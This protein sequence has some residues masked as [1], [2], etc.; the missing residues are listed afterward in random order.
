[1]AAPI[2]S[3]CSNVTTNIAICQIVAPLPWAGLKAASPQNTQIAG[4]CF[5]WASFDMVA[6]STGVGTIITFQQL[7]ADSFPGNL[8]W[9]TLVTGG[10]TPA[11][12]TITLANSTG[13]GGVLQGPFWGLQLV[14]S[15]VVGNGVAY[16]R[17]SGSI[18][19]S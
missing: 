2:T 3:Y 1:M 8:I 5:D 4:N 18:R 10:V 19:T 15:G 17:L 7:G 13:Y 11:A 12:T 6:G 9:R 14:I 16:A